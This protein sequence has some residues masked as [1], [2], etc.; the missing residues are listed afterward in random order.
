MNDL[1]SRIL[2]HIYSRDTLIMY[3]YSMHRLAS[4]SLAP[5]NGLV[6]RE[7]RPG[8]WRAVGDI[9][10]TQRAQ[11]TVFPP[12]FDEA[13]AYKRLHN[14]GYCFVCEDKGRIVGYTWFAAG[15]GHITVIQST[16]RLKERQAYAYNAYVI[17]GY[18]GANIF[19]DLLVTGARALLLK[20]FTDGVAYAMTGNG[21]SRAVL[22][23]VAF[24]DIGRVTVGY[25]LTIRYLTNT[26]R[27]ICLLS[28]ASP[29][30]F[31][32]KLFGKLS[33]ALSPAGI[34]SGRRLKRP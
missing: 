7:L 10:A 15:E 34:S 14:G 23:K 3:E 18:R 5:A 29:F 12:A 22:P 4:A 9:L 27:D 25:F 17:K 20:G 26:C 33:A 2:R 31:Y 8:E 32:R 11:D 13:E 24:S 16:I 30:E 6:F 21:A 1:W 19:R 28:H